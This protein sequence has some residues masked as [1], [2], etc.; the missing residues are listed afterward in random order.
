MP[1]TYSTPPAD[2]NTSWGAWFRT[3]L[4]AIKTIIDTL[5]TAL[6]GK[7]ATTHTH[8]ISGVSGLQSALD[9]KADNSDLTAKA[10]A[11]ATSAA[12]AQRLRLDATQTLTSA[13]RIQAW[14]NLDS[15]R[16]DET[17]YASAA[18]LASAKPTG[19]AGVI[20]VVLG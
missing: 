9:G 6:S 7:A 20:Y 15:M 19:E 4:A 14:Q 3:T 2:G 1:L 11:T 18:A 10:D 8:S 12:L 16:I 13:Q 17:L 5:E